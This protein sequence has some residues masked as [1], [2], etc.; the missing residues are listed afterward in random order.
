[1]SDLNA[2]EEPKRAAGTA[3]AALVEDGMRLGLGTGS[4]VRWFLE[5][6]AGRRLDVAGIP[7]SKDTADRCRALGIELLDPATVVHLDLAVDG[8]DEFDEELTATKGG[9]GALLREKVVASMAERFVLVATPDKAVDRLGDT[10]PLPIEVVPFALGPVTHTLR[11]QGANPTERHHPDGRSYRTDNGNAIVD[12]HYP[13]G[14][15]DPAVTELS[16][17]MIPGVVANGLF[18]ELATLAVLGHVDGRVEHRTP[19]TGVA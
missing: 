9:G 2:S 15:E 3:A 14:I 16:L 6:L 7:T 11:G 1:V 4:T 13:G 17:S 12:A 5:A 19:G 10:F 18:V 8:A